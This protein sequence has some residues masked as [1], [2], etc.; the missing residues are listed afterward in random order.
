MSFRYDRDRIHCLAFHY[1]G[2]PKI[3][4]AHLGRQDATQLSE[5]PTWAIDSAGGERIEVVEAGVK[6]IEAVAASNEFW[7]APGK[8]RFPEHGALIRVK[9][10]LGHAKRSLNLGHEAN[11]A[12]FS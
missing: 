10:G 9:C 5:L 8:Y 2:S 6:R 12:D 3:P 4:E 11:F 7:D 1:H